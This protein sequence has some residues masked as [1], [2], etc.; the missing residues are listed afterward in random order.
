MGWRRRVGLRGIFAIAVAAAS[1][2]GSVTAIDQNDASATAGPAAG[3]AGRNP[4]PG[5]APGSGSGGAGGS[6]T[7]DVAAA[8]PCAVCAQADACCK[9]G[10]RGGCGYTAACAAAG[11]SDE[12]QLR[13]AVCQSV[14]SVDVDGGGTHCKRRMEVR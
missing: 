5:K 12:Q 2:C 13:V 14:L 4:G 10:G 6:V 3:P 8:L 11:T 7:V 9:A 1:A